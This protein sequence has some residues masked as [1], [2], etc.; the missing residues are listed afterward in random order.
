MSEPLTVSRH[1]TQTPAQSGFKEWWSHNQRKV[2]PYLF[3]TPTMIIFTT[4]VLIPIVYAGFIS[5]FKW[6]G[7]SEAEFVGV[8]NY[9]RLVE[10]PIFW[11][12]LQNTV[13]FTLGVVPFSMG[14]GLLAA[15]GLNR[16]HLPGRAIL[17]TVY[18]LPFVISAVATATTAGWIFGDTFGVLNKILVELGFQKVQWLTNRHTALLTVIIVTI[19]I[20]LGF[21]MLIYL[22]GLQS[23][24]SDLVE[25]A[26]VD[27][28]TVRQQFFRITL[29]LL[30]PTTFL[31]V[32]LNVIYSFE[33]FDLVYV[34]TNGGPGYST[35]VLT[36]FIYNAAFQTKSMGYASAIGIVFMAIIMTITLIQWRIS[37][38]GGRIT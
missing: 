37:N 21:C 9:T 38:E 1:R 2:V 33:V 18:F 35:T 23:I 11:T 8:R 29:P 5:F 34:M 13:L 31:L 27:G 28:A 19:W 36:V 14:L 15:L 10:D 25:A 6:N 16:K 4:F 30:K 32:V 22:A 20:R 3:I 24:P 26:K 17:R 7:I 12:S